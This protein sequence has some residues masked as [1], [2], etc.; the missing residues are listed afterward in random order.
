MND[1]PHLKNAPIVESVF[2]FRVSLP[3][4]FTIEVLGAA[5]GR[6]P[7]GYGAAKAQR[8]WMGEITLAPEHSP[9]QTVHD[10]GVTGYAF[11]SSDGKYVAQFRRNG[12]SFSRLTPYSAW[13]D[14]FEKAIGFWRLYVEIAAPV[15]VTRLAVRTINRIALLEGV[16]ELGAYLTAPPS[17]PPGVPNCLLSFLS[18]NVVQDE[19]TGVAAN[20]IQTIEPADAEGKRAIILD[21]DVFLERRFEPEDERLPEVFASLRKLKNV[22]FFNSLTP[23]MIDR[24]K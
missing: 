11:H 22:I 12:F 7:E 14:V 20:V 13:K 4:D 2:D 8:G 15:E 18:Q 23:A 21:C 1:F 10:L 16:S 9:Q 24:Y 17:M 6:L 5:G 19:E 3:P